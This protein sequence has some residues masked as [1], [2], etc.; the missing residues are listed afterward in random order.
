MTMLHSTLS[1]LPSL[2]EFVFDLKCGQARQ[3][4]CADSG[5]KVERGERVGVK[6]EGEQLEYARV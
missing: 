2:G 1:L 5:L 6:T 3:A 4:R